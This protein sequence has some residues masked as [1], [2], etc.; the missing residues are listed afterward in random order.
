[1]VDWLAGM[2]WNGTYGKEHNLA[3]AQSHDEKYACG[4]RS[5]LGWAG[6]EHNEAGYALL[7][8]ILVQRCSLT[9]RDAW[10][11]WTQFSGWRGRGS[12]VWTV[13]VPISI[14]LVCYALMHVIHGF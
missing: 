1:M 3:F 13:S 6:S 4:A 10:M 14:G 9:L 5:G 7:S 2:S 8:L 11:G 12:C